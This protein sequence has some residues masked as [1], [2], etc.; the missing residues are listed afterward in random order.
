MHI[1][2][3][4]AVAQDMWSDTAG[5][6]ALSHAYESVTAHTNHLSGYAWG[7]NIGWVSFGAP[8]GGPYGNSSA[9]DWGVNIDGRG[10]LSGYA[11]SHSAGWINFGAADVSYNRA[12]GHFSGNAWGERIGWIHCDTLRRDRGLEAY[13]PFNGNAN[14]ASGNGHDG[15]VIRAEVTPT[16]FGRGYKFTDGDNIISFSGL[17]DPPDMTRKAFSVEWWHY[18]NALREEGQMLSA[19]AGKDGFCFHTAADGSLYV[20]TDEAT[21]FTPNDLPA[22]TMVVG[23]WQHLVFT[24]DNGR[25]AFYR[26]GVLLAS[27]DDMSQARRWLGFH[28]GDSVD[29]IVDELRIYDRALTGI[30]AAAHYE[31]D[32]PGELIQW[33][34][35]DGGNGHWYG[36]VSYNSTWHQARDNAALHSFGGSTGHL[37]SITSLEECTFVRNCLDLSSRTWLGAY[38]PSGVLEPAGG[39][40]WLTG[41]PWNF[42]YWSSGQPD[43]AGGTEHYLHQLEK[44]GQWDD[45]PGTYSCP[46]YLLEYSPS[47]LDKDGL[48][49][50][51]E[52]TS[53]GDLATSDGTGDADHDGFSD[54]QEGDAGT[55]PNILSRTEDLLAYLPFDSSLSDQSGN[56][57]NADGNSSFGSDIH[58]IGSQAVVLDGADSFLQLPAFSIAGAY[59]VSV[60]IYTENPHQRDVRIIDFGNGQASDNLVLGLNATTGKMLFDSYSGSSSRYISSPDVFPSGQWVQV[61]AVNDG[62]GNGRLYW[63]GIEV[64]SGPMYAANDLSRTNQYLGRTNGSGSDF[65][66]SLDEFRVYNRALSAGEIEQLYFADADS[67]SD[68]LLDAWERE[69]FG[70]LSS[71]HAGTDTDGD[72]YSDAN[73]VNLGTDP[74]IPFEQDALL[75]YYTLDYDDDCRDITGNGYDGTLV[76]GGAHVYNRFGAY[77]KAYEFSEASVA[78]LPVEMLNGLSN[79]TFV[80]W[81]R[82]AQT[83]TACNIIS[84]VQ[85]GDADALCL[86]V[87]ADGRLQ[88]CWLGTILEAEPI[89]DDDLWHMI[90]FTVDADAGRVTLSIDGE[91]ETVGT[92]SGKSLNIDAAGMTLGDGFDGAIDD[93]RFYSRAL[94]PSE[95]VRLS[96]DYDQH[97]VLA[98]P[99]LGLGL[100]Y[101]LWVREGEKVYIPFAND[102]T[103]F[104]VSISTPPSHGTA[105]VRNNGLWY[106][107]NSG[108]SGTE[109]FW[110]LWESYVSGSSVSLINAHVLSTNDIPSISGTPPASVVQDS[111]YEFQPTVVDSD[112]DTAPLQFDVVGLPQWATFDYTTG[113]MVGTPS[114]RD[115]GIYPDIVISVWDGRAIAEMGPFSI[116]VVD[117]PDAPVVHFPINDQWALQN[118]RFEMQVGQTFV[119]EDENDELALSLTLANGSDLPAWLQFDS[120]SGHIWGVPGEGAAGETELCLTAIDSSGLRASS[121]FILSIVSGQCVTGLKAAQRPG[122]KLVEITYDITSHI[123][124]DVDIR[125]SIDNDG[126]LVPASSLSGDVGADV[127]AGTSKMIV[128]NAGA[129]WNNDVAELRISLMADDADSFT[130][131]AV[132]SVSCDTRNYALNVKSGGYGDPI[133]PV[134]S[135]NLCWRSTVTCSAGTETGWRCTGWVGTGSIP[136]TGTTSATGRIILDQVSSSITWNWEIIDNDGDGMGDLWEVASFGNLDQPADGDYDAD[137]RTNAEEEGDGTD[138]TS[139]GDTLGL[140]ACYPFDGNANDVANGHHGQTTNG[141]SASFD[142][143]GDS[144]GAYD[145]DGYDDRIKIPGAVL[146]GK[147]SVAISAWLL[148]RDDGLGHEEDLLFGATAT[149]Q[150]DFVVGFSGQGIDLHIKGL[151]LVLDA[152]GFK[153]SRWHNIVLQRA[154]GDIAL[155]IDGVK[156][157]VMADPSSGSLEIHPDGLWIGGARDSVGDGWA[158]NQQFNGKA[159]DV[160]IYDRALS[161]NEVA[162]LYAATA[163]M[164]YTVTLD[165]RGGT[166]SSCSKSVVCGEPYG[167]FPV[168]QRTGYTFGGWWTG[169]GGTGAHVNASTPMQVVGDHTLYAAWDVMTYTVAFDADGGSDSPASRVIVYDSPYGTLPEPVR[170][171]YSFEGWWTGA[172]ATGSPVVANTLVTTVGDRTLY[173]KWS[174]NAYWVILDAEGGSLGTSGQSVFFGSAYGSLPEPVRFGWFF[175]GWWS[176]DNGTEQ[177]ID[178]GTMVVVMDNHTLHAKWVKNA[179]RVDFHAVEGTVDPTWTMVSL[180][181]PYGDLP[182]PVRP[183]YT[184]AGWWTDD[185][186]TGSMVDGNTMVNQGMDHTLYACWIVNA[187]TVSFDPRGGTVGITGRTVLLGTPYDSLPEPIRP[188]YTFEGWWIAEDGSGTVVVAETIMTTTNDHTLFAKWSAN[189]YDVSFDA[190]GGFVDTLWKTSI[191]NQSY[192]PLPEPTRSGYAFAGWWS[193]DNATGTLVGPDTILLFAWNHTLY[194][195]WNAKNFTVTLATEGGAVD[196]QTINVVFYGLYG[197]LPIPEREGFTFLGWGLEPDGIETGVTASTVVAA[198]EDHTLYAKW[199]ANTYHLFYD[200]EG[201]D[202][203]PLTR[204]VLFGAVYGLHPAPE[205]SG[206][207]FEGWWLFGGEIQTE[208]GS[209][210]VVSLAANHTLH[211]K[212]TPESYAMVYDAQGGSLEYGGKTVRFAEPYGVLPEPIL[213]GYTFG[214]WWTEAEGSGTRVNAGTLVAAT[215]D[216]TLFAV[217]APISCLVTFDPG[218]ASVDSSTGSVI[219]DASYGELPEPVWP[220]YS[221]DGWWTGVGGAGSVVEASTIVETTEDHILYARWIPESYTIS[222]EAAGGTVDSP[223]VEVTYGAIYGNL[224]VTLR[225]GYTFEGWWTGA[226]GSG[227]LVEKDTLVTTSAD[228]TLYANWIPVSCTVILDIGEGLG[229]LPDLIVNFGD[230]YGRL[231]EPTRP[232]HTFEGWWLDVNGTGDPVVS[233][234]IVTT[235]ADHILYGRWV[236]NAYVVSFDA[237][238]SVV[239]P[240]ARDVTFGEPY[241]QLVQPVRPGYAFRGWWTGAEGSGTEVVEDSSVTT[242]GDHTLHAKWD[243]LQRLVVGIAGGPGETSISDAWYPAGDEVLVEVT[244]SPGYRLSRWLIDGTDANEWTGGEVHVGNDSIRLVMNASY[245]V[246][247]LLEGVSFPEALETT[248]LTWRA[249]GNA[250]WNVTVAETHDGEDAVQSGAIAHAAV[251]WIETTVNG[252]GNLTYWWKVSSE[253]GYDWLRLYVDEKSKFAVSGDRGW[254]MV[255]L[256]ISGDGD[257]RL[258]WEYSKDKSTSSGIDG[259]WLDEVKWLPKRTF[260]AWAS[261]QGFS[262]DPELLFA[263]DGNGD[264]VCNGFEFAFGANWQSGEALS[265]LAIVDGRPVLEFPSQDPST[266]GEVVIRVLWS[267]DLHTWTRVDSSGLES[268]GQEGNRSRLVVPPG[269]GG[270]AFY[271]LEA[272]YNPE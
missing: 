146:N 30:E 101:D 123:A 192:G 153:D 203:A 195:K 229:D 93:V 112:G 252:S 236:A 71:T 74:N 155:Y 225:T 105:E 17:A 174:A 80:A 220:G 95:I 35:E 182:M 22:G 208:V 15:L 261:E 104:K 209:T 248:G 46:A 32:C 73:E 262:G 134:S 57:R 163:P 251:S 60:W 133:P 78:K 28:I 239:N 48:D 206:Y 271:R 175:A 34:E 89:L 64:V 12:S 228:H 235:D 233:G 185:G 138:P 127:T 4:P 197:A 3:G 68:G 249:G 272:D 27:K 111:L 260:A 258:R 37:A 211:A 265:R 108:N 136:S 144:S 100:K 256:Q 216:H 156:E 173:A 152:P 98:L 162:A 132:V 52:R 125:V 113:L 23:E 196:P 114:G 227:A 18:P 61:V 190:E 72:G 154:D 150:N 177:R 121:E 165:A 151:H 21:R 149:D 55:D 142:R 26:N 67:D 231:P 250:P 38:Q 40:A 25:A 241:G 257:H 188:G 124:D 129:D 16:P 53:F 226:G 11:W 5:S 45:V 259:A 237:G 168:P 51:W 75:A 205:R 14:D 187:Y 91:I 87:T 83:N 143:F 13:Y 199:S 135:T 122:T 50:G 221:F 82:T 2:C 63:D 33:R 148:I 54:A 167:T 255:T 36:L 49:D 183:G 103:I 218:E 106:A 96:G 147:D 159:D 94:S 81:V 268:V 201:G 66:G 88:L 139:A 70:D 41:E 242:E 179:Y 141:V 24:F 247:A 176:G 120:A 157:V 109:Q 90:A 266:A 47:D 164:A 77:S 230:P 267:D 130:S 19:A 116:E 86:D 92:C 118:R 171:G 186:G 44:Y 189:A 102:P 8:A 222:F 253:A 160:R 137:G 99:A 212:W 131:V 254:V 62:L 39:W 161:S 223:E 56:G 217:W 145:F 84:G 178:V 180:N 31:E 263:A 232:G 245:R 202:V 238:E 219:F 85:G 264:G 97:A 215:N 6:I 58:G 7:E 170:L 240:P 1:S 115:V 158:V 76:T 244:P 172:N 59:S 270:R 117:R 79:L 110:L 224:P 213:R 198:T 20:G 194:A 246:T 119:D 269:S 43:N 42:T 166:V 69:H 234:T 169:L 214:G 128:W 181:T 9:D 65:A 126:T 184:F 210:S 29:G 10:R 204:D 140:I 200:G 107:P 207:V 193:G 243:M 191:Y